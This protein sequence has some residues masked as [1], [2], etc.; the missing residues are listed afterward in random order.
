[1]SSGQLSVQAG[2]ASYTITNGTRINLSALKPVKLTEAPQPLFQRMVE[3]QESMLQ[4][5]YSQ[6]PD[7]SRHS[8]YQDYAQVMVGGK[9]VARLD[10][11]GGLLTSNAVA[12]TLDGR[13]PNIG[14]TGKSGPLLA[15]AR[16][17][18]V[19]K[20]LGGKVA[21][22]DTAI[23]QERYDTLPKPKPVVNETAMKEDPVYQRIQETKKARLLFL[24]QQM[25]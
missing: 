13:F 25:A 9:E 7:I 20:L 22:A 5:R 8:G 17:E 23:T 24:A 2:S 14:P 1:M 10:N 4:S 18:A 19:A 15:Q 16:A 6:A 21:M 11:N 3:A 12:A